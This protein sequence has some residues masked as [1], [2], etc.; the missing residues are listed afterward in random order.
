MSSYQR[1]N[2][3][4]WRDDED[5]G[6][7]QEALLLPILKDFFRTNSLKQ[8]P[9]KYYYS[10]FVDTDADGCEIGYEVKTRECYSTYE[11][12]HEEGLVINTKKLWM[13]EFI[14][15]NFWD[16]VFY[17]RVKPEQVKTFLRTTFQR[18]TRA[19]GHENKVDDVTYI[20]FNVF[21]LLHVY[22]PERKHHE[23]KSNTDGAEQR[24]GRCLI[25]VSS[26]F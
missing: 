15:F 7:D 19:C 1:R 22:N 9:D 4:T 20:P 12:L 8:H 6:R 23:V 16:K 11:K 25:D 17:Y 18:E 21:S 13:N 24:R 5:F 26:L 14:I 3:A 2:N 10:D